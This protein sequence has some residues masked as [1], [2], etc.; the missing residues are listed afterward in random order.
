MHRTI[1]VLFF[2]LLNFFGVQK[3]FSQDLGVQ[4]GLDFMKPLKSGGDTTKY[5][6]R[7]G[8]RADFAYLIPD[9]T[10]PVSSTTT[11][12]YEYFLAITDTAKIE[13][14][15]LMSGSYKDT[16]VLAKTSSYALT[17]NVGYEIPQETSEFLMINVN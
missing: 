7:T 10:F 15:D 16:N 4:A 2:L 9:Y 14:R 11:I 6:M 5:K 17:F 12:G 8:I 1:F 13:L 3:S